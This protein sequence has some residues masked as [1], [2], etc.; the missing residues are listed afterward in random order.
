MTNPKV[1][2]WNSNSEEHYQF[3]V[4]RSEA[5]KLRETLGEAPDLGSQKSPHQA[6]QGHQAQRRSYTVPL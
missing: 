2:N 4:G 5:E 1:E 3:S 6:G